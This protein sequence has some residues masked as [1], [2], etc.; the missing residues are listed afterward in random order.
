MWK[1]YQNTFSASLLTDIQP[2]KNGMHMEREGLQILRKKEQDY[3]L[4]PTY[5]NRK[6]LFSKTESKSQTVSNKM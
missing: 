6:V 4:Q 1:L 5:I 3:S 2:P